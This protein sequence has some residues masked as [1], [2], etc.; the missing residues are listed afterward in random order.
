MGYGYAKE[1]NS[2]KGRRNKWEKHAD[3]EMMLTSMPEY[4]ECR[5]TSDIVLLHGHHARTLE[6][7]CVH[8]YARGPASFVLGYRSWTLFVKSTY[9]IT[10][11]LLKIVTLV[12]IASKRPFTG[13]KEYPL[14]SSYSQKMKKKNVLLTL[15]TKCT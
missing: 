15:F 11:I 7:G 14:S 9:P 12:R 4:K 6:K 10:E 13:K 8:I 1:W 5:D 2:L 3:R